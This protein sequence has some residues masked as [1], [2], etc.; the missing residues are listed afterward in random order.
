MP[1][2]LEKLD[3][4]KLRNLMANARRLGDETL[5]AQAFAR[6]CAILPNGGSEDLLDDVLVQKFWKAVHAAEQ[7]KSEQNG[8]TTRL[9]RTRQ[10]VAKDGVVATMES[11][12]LKPKPSDGFTILVD[13][14]LPHL[15][16][17]YIIAEHPDRFSAEARSA[18][19]KRLRDFGISLP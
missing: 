6:L 19:H 10:K 1:L 16:F 12:A 13:Y 9:S 2:D 17:E 3:A 18:A 8:K 5:Y 11:M 15:V 14:S 4:E 7:I